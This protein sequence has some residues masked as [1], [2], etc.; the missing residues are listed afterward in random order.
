[1]VKE[2][3]IEQAEEIVET[4]QAIDNQIAEESDFVNE[5]SE[6]GAD[7]DYT[8]VSSDEFDFIL[9]SSSL[10]F[11]EVQLDQLDLGFGGS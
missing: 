9:E 1:M 2:K 4:R 8:K 11:D 5:N 10:M 6:V 3:I 7:E